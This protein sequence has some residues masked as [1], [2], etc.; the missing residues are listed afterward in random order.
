MLYKKIKKILITILFVAS[1]ALGFKV[2]LHNKYSKQAFIPKPV[3]ELKVDVNK[4][5][6]KEVL[7]THKITPYEIYVTLPG[8]AESYIK[9]KHQS[10]NG[11]YKI[12][13]KTQLKLENDYVIHF[14]YDISQ[15][16]FT[17]NG[18][19]TYTVK[20]DPDKITTYITTQKERITDQTSNYIGD[21]FPNEILIQ[22]LAAMRNDA[23]QQV[24]TQ[25]NFQRT[26]TNVQNT[27]IHIFK[28]LGIDTTKVKFQ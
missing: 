28:S 22:K 11:I 2:F 4:V 20:L 12:L 6:I 25:E 15:S 8:Y 18:D 13:T 3:Y 19:G 10:L 17:D 23:L 7:N 16:K 21:E 14:A 5:K 1:L 26:I 9:P 27:L 24:C